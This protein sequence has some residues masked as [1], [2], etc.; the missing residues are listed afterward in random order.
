MKHHT[1]YMAIGILLFSLSSCHKNCIGIIGKGSAVTEQ[2][3]YDN[4]DRIN[5][6]C[7]ADLE[8]TQ[9][10]TWFV[11][12]RGQSNILEVLKTEQEGSS[13]A[14]SF[15]KNVLKH[16]GL[17]IVVHTPR[18]TGLDISGSGNITARSALAC[19]HLNLHI[20]GSGNINLQSLQAATLDASI[21]GSGNI[22]GAAGKT[23]NQKLSISGSGNIDLRNLSCNSSSCRISG[24][25]DMTVN[26][27]E[28]LEVTISGS[29]NLRYTGHPQI[30]S[31]IS[32]SGTVRSL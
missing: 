28:T 9:D 1:L 25:G 4:F 2:R 5:L 19:N 22:S 21:S 6:H 13:L 23:D 17:T 26:A 31:N 15:S 18:L 30:N 27:T 24:S 29:G 32:G 14:F 11:E 12:L 8:Y 20:S 10:S 16:S 7:D 3:Q